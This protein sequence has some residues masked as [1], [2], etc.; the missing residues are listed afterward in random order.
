LVAKWLTQG[1]IVGPHFQVVRYEPDLGILT[2]RV[3]DSGNL[4]KA[5]VRQYIADV[6]TVDKRYYVS[7]LVVTLRSLVTSTLSFDNA[8]PSVSS[9]CTIASAFKFV[10]KDGRVWESSGKMEA[11]FLQTLK[12]RYAEHGLDY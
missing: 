3:T 8:Q 11:E 9:S 2:F 1:L 6:S 12:D 4:T 5:D 7:E 10:S